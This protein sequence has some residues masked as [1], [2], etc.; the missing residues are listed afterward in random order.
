MSRL[1][2]LM[3]MLSEDGFEVWI[4]GDECALMARRRGA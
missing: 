4:D 3:R 1:K 2:A